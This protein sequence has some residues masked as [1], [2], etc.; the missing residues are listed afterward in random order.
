MSDENDEAH[1]VGF[2]LIA[3]EILQKCKINGNVQSLKECSDSFF[4]AIYEGILGESLEG[5]ITNAVSYEQRI[6]NCSKVIEALSHDVLNVDLSHIT[7]ENIVEGDVPTIQN[8]LEIF[9]ELLDFILDVDDEFDLDNAGEQDDSNILSSDHEVISDVLQEELGPSTH[10]FRFTPK[11]TAL[12]S[13]GSTVG[14]PEL[15]SIPKCSDVPSSRNSDLDSN[16]TDEII[17]ESELLER[18]FLRDYPSLRK[19]IKDQ[20][21]PVHPELATSGRIHTLDECSDPPRYEEK[22]PKGRDEATTRDRYTDGRIREVC[23][24]GTTKDTRVS[25]GTTRD[26]PGAR[27]TITGASKPSGTTRY[28]SGPK[29]TT[30]DTCV[31]MGTTRDA[32]LQSGSTRDIH[33]P[34]GTTRDASLQSG[35]NRDTRVPSGTTR[36]ASLQSG[37]S[38]D[39]PPIPSD[40]ARNAIRNGTTGWTPVSSTDKLPGHAD[41]GDTIRRLRDSFTKPVT[42]PTGLQAKSP[43]HSG[44]YPFGTGKVGDERGYRKRHDYGDSLTSADT[45]HKSRDLTNTEIRTK[46][47]PVKRAEFPKHAKGRNEHAGLT[48]R[49][50]LSSEEPGTT[51]ASLT[52][53]RNGDIPSKAKNDLQ[54]ENGLTARGARKIGV[55]DTGSDFGEAPI[56]SKKKS[57]HYRH[58]SDPTRDFTDINGPRTVDAKSRP[59]ALGIR[60]VNRGDRGIGRDGNGYGKGKKGEKD[61]R[62]RGVVGGQRGSRGVKV[63]KEGIEQRKAIGVKGGSIE[64]KEVGQKEGD[65]VNSVVSE[66]MK[67]HTDGSESS[68]V[69]WDDQISPLDVSERLRN[70]SQ[71]LAFDE[72]GLAKKSS[73]YEA[74]HQRLGKEKESRDTPVVRHYHH[75]F[76]HASSEDLVRDVDLSERAQSFE[77]VARSRNNEEL[78]SSLT[79]KD[80]RNADPEPRHTLRKDVLMKKD[81]EISLK[82]RSVK[83]DDNV[84]TFLITNRL[85]RL[86]RDMEIERNEQNRRG[87]RIKNGYDGYLDRLNKEHRR[88]EKELKGIPKKTKKSSPYRAKRVV[89]PSPRVPQKKARYT[90]TRARKRSSSASPKVRKKKKAAKQLEKGDVILPTLLDEFPFLHL[91]PH[92]LQTMRKKQ[93]QQLLNLSKSSQADKRQTKTQKVIEDAE[94]RQQTL[95]KILRKDLQHNERMR[96]QKQRKEQERAIRSRLR[97]KRHATARAR[98]YY[99][100]YQLRMRARMLKR[101]TKEEQVFKNLFEDGL[102]IQKQRVRELRSYAKEQRE[103][104]ALKQQNELESIENYYHDQYSILA[105]AIAQEKEALLIRE[106]AQEKVIHQM[107]R[108]LRQKLQKEVSDIQE[109]LVRDEDDAYFRRLDAERLRR[110][111]QMTAFQNLS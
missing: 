36:D 11:T 67:R 95:L 56:R 82:K 6:S 94:K 24:S 7:A 18:Q 21:V 79:R 108:N 109:T 48:K 105:E 30:W 78:G 91:S 62:P 16:S 83:F 80:P 106:K 42:I 9:K 8:L 73:E 45:K 29:G 87:M 60:R 98:R 57:T 23:V 55:Q 75:H 61:K 46:D 41:D 43:D 44:E 93:T 64:I 104:R 81:D 103:L 33:V 107:Q 4:I 14:E 58:D 26:A 37:T 71:G 40:T 35:T 28:D 85:E 92:T 76:H 15:S 20:G 10:A 88:M 31:P 110:Q 111:L 65:A 27:G 19:V 68:G 38:R 59:G 102:E 99:E 84:D 17:R 39:A 53:R 3:N 72:V 47:R 25:S 63:M 69:F 66:D 22:L 77:N 34:R 86:K 50:E 101:R 49:P 100:D 54:S 32:S 74:R 51:A 97:E 12:S 96:E 13:D 5:I 70:P 1:D 52:A 89:S 2:V 90:S